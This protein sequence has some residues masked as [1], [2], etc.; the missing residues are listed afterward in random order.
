[1]GKRKRGADQHHN[2]NDPPASSGTFFFKIFL[3]VKFVCPVLF[4]FREN[5]D[6]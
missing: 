2:S 5:V 6:N 3:F 1:M 4:G